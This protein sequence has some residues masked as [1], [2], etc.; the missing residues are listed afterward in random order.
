[1]IDERPVCYEPHPVTKER[2]AELL[3]EGWR[4]LDAAFKP[5]EEP[6]QKLE[7]TAE[8]QVK[9]SATKAAKKSD[10]KQA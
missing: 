1:M 3:A 9:A 6:A 4:I 7:P 2:K 5:A 10:L 8:P